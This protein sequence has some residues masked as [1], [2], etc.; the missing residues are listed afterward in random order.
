VHLLVAGA[1]RLLMS[2][3]MLLHPPSV[4]VQHLLHA[5]VTRHEHRNHP[6]EGCAFQDRRYEQGFPW[7]GVTWVRNEVLWTVV[8]VVYVWTVV[9]GTRGS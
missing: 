8:R 2:G 4:I 1:Y 6:G 7:R 5:P 3:V 9:E